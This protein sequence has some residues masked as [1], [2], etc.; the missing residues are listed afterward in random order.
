VN[1]RHKPAGARRD[2]RIAPVAENSY[3]P[4][5]TKRQKS[6]KSRQI[7]EGVANVESTLCQNSTQLSGRYRA[8]Q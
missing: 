6:E 4:Q 2:H 3:L 7:R 5:R 8:E 1:W